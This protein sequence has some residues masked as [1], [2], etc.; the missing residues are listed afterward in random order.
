MRL[1]DER[2]DSLT[3][4]TN[5]HQNGINLFSHQFV[6]SPWGTLCPPCCHQ[7]RWR[8]GWCWGWSPSPPPP[9]SA[10]SPPPPPSSP[11]S[12][13]KLDHMLP[14]AEKAR[15]GEF[16]ENSVLLN[17]QWILVWPSYWGREPGEIERMEERQQ[18]K[19]Q[20]VATDWS[21]RRAWSLK[22]VILRWF[23]QKIWK[24]PKNANESLYWSSRHVHCFVQS[25]FF[26]TY[27][28]HPSNWLICKKRIR[29]W[30][31]QFQRYLLLNMFLSPHLGNVEDPR[32]KFAPSSF[33][34][35]PLKEE[36][37]MSS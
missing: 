9:P 16:V 18:V 4:L 25:H 6:G 15:Y 34:S 14:Q 1:L 29:L 8:W 35:W 23:V 19:Q 28:I 17:L 31:N 22:W 30:E 7:G 33:R 13:S 3:K 21:S 36:Q 11:L 10:A 5:R 37:E 2:L 24:S 27:A 32:R 12:P 20:L 26:N